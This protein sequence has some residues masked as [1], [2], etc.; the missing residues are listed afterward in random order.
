MNMNYRGAE[1]TEMK[2]GCAGLNAHD[3][4]TTQSL[5]SVLSAPSVVNL[6]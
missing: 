4:T 6:S 1:G 5:D 3:T 2:Q